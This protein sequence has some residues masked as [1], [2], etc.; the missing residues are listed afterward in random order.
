[1]CD[2]ALVDY[3]LSLTDKIFMNVQASQN[4]KSGKITG[5]S[6]INK[7]LSFLHLWLGLA[8]GIVLIVVALTGSIL[9]FEEELTPVLFAKEQRVNSMQTRLSAD[10]LVTIAK[11]V[12]PKDKIFRM[13]F[14]AEADRS[15]KA[16]FGTKKKGY[17]YVYI[18]P[19]TG[20]ILS[21]GAENKRFFPV[22]LNIHRYLLAGDFGKAITGISCAITFF[23]ACS[24][25]YLWWPKNKKV[26]KQRLKVKTDASFK[27]VNWDLHGVGCFY[28]MSGLVIITLTG[29]IWSYDWVENLLFTITNSKIEKTEVVENPNLNAKKVSGIY[30]IIVSKSNEIYTHRGKMTITFPD[31]KDKSILL[32][33]ENDD[34]ATSAAD[35]LFFDSKTAHLIRAKSFAQLDLGNKIRKLNKPIHTGSIFGWPTK[36][37][38]FLTTLI[39]ASLP[40]TGL[41]I[42]LGKKKKVKKKPVLS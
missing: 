18:N 34:Q 30:E 16:T 25:L 26:L 11:T 31:K 21:N 2:S 37:L 14:P 5:Q 7:V 28:A 12:Y 6:A 29:L 19:Y 24:G 13:V 27:R 23:L 8:A 32:A 20:E 36:I 41:L 4:K 38:A 10:S 33:K 1:L 35:Q 22:V 9:T 17:K 42:Y 3:Q 40:I 39:T 15:I